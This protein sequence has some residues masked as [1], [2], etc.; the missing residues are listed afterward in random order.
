MTGVQTCDLPISYTPIYYYIGHFSK[1]IQKGAYRIA[2]TK[3]DYRLHVCGFQNP[4]G[5]IVLVVMNPT[6]EVIPSIIRHNG[7]CANSE[8][9]PHSIMTVIL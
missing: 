5:S 6:D 7:I 2:T 9:Q 1:Y 3:H 8:M 4:D